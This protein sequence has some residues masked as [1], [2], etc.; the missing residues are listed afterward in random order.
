MQSL[1]FENYAETLKIYL[2][3]YREVQYGWKT[4]RKH[5]CIEASIH[6]YLD[7]QAGASVLFW[8]RKR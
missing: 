1:G 6:V 3:K 7:Y 4:I 8:K 5:E 2:Q